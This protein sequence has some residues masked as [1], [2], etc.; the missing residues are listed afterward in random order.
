M[1]YPYSTQQTTPSGGKGWDATT[2]L[3]VII[4]LIILFGIAMS[5]FRAII[6][7]LVVALITAYLLH[8]VVEFVSRWTRMPYK[9]ATGVI[10]LI[11]LA[12]IILLVALL[13]P[14]VGKQVEVLIA[15]LERIIAD[16][17]SLSTQSVTVVG[18]EVE[19]QSIVDEVG[20]TLQEFA[21]S[22]AA[23]VPEIAFGVAETLLLV[24]FIFLMAFYLTRD[25]HE[26]RDWLR[27]LIPPGYQ[28]DSDLLF[29]ELDAVWMAF[30][31]GQLTLAIIVAVII[32]IVATIIGLPQ[33]IFWGVFAGLMEFLPS[34][35]HAIYLIVAMLVALVEGSTTLPISNIAFVAVVA[36]AH[37]VFTQFD[38]N[39]LIPRIIGA[40]VHLH[41]MVV[42]IGIIIG[43]S[44]GGVLGVALAAPVIA[45]VRVLGRYV[46][47]RL[48]SMEPFPEDEPAE[49]L[50]VGDEVAVE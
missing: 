23:D 1:N 38:L 26:I 33:P 36:G 27:A 28:R 40:Q 2:R 44:V 9:V 21:T 15:E 50:P 18:F 34:V 37:T 19:V 16:I 14:V 5:A 24:I 6:V 30:F 3:V 12:G 47:A 17:L 25:V 39:Y 43:A 46:Y 45:S 49:P 31:R 8:P 20:Q 4:F 42:I 35:G 22:V 32:T 29:A 7:P 11:L 10:Y 13:T 48:F 41:P